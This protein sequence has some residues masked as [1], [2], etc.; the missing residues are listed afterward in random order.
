MHG[1][2]NKK[3]SLDGLGGLEVRIVIHLPV[4]HI[5]SHKNRMLNTKVLLFLKKQKFSF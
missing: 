2:K 3:G 5:G 1:G 4:G